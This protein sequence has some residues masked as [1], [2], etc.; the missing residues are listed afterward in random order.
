MRAAFCA[1]F[2]LT[3]RSS[4]SLLLSHAT[5]LFKPS[6]IQIPKSPAPSPQNT[7][8]SPFTSPSPSSESCLIQSERVKWD[9]SNPGVWEKR[10]LEALKKQCQA[11]MQRGSFWLKLMAPTGSNWLSLRESN[12]GIE[13]MPDF[14]KRRCQWPV[15]KI[16]W[17]GSFPN[18]QQQYS[19]ETPQPRDDAVD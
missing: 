11:N 18:E 3:N 2:I 13:S 12:C 16:Y 8:I 1:I 6:G 15:A 17:D 7:A 10:P 5:T 4:L 19:N 9:N 14:F